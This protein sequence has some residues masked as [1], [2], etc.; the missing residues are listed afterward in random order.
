MKVGLLLAIANLWFATPALAQQQDNA[1]RGATL[2]QQRCGA[3]HSM[4]ANRVGPMHRGVHGR[5]A[6]AAP[7]FRYSPALQRLGV[8]WNDA[9]LDRWLAAPTTMA[10]GT[11]MG[12]VTPDARDRADI[13]AY[14]R[15]PAAH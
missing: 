11:T 8:T 15:S 10:P 6:G 13:I 4:D 2:Y 7:G 14:L 12:M 3:C 5:R 1:A 9:T